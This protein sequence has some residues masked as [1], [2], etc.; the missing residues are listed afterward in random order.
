MPVCFCGLHHRSLG[1]CRQVGLVA[2]PRTARK[3]PGPCTSCW[4][5]QVLTSREGLAL[6]RWQA[7]RLALEAKMGLQGPGALQRPR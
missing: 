1:A 7:A 3:P 2:D 4:P 5:L 6:A